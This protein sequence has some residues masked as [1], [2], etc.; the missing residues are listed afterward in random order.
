MASCAM[1]KEGALVLLRQ[2]CVRL[3]L[4]LQ[5]AQL[6][7]QR[8]DVALQRLNAAALALPVPGDA[9]QGQRLCQ[10]RTGPEAAVLN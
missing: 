10:V 6:L 8:I 1:D 3:L 2:R 5:L 4:H 9:R 7:L